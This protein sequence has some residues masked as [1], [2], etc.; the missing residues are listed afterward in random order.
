MCDNRIMRCWLVLLAIAAVRAECPLY[1]YSPDGVN[2][3]DCPVEIDIDATV[4]PG[5]CVPMLGYYNVGV[6][7]YYEFAHCT[8]CA[9]NQLVKTPCTAV[10]NTVCLTCPAFAIALNGACTCPANYYNNSVCIPCPAGSQSTIGSTACTQCPPDTYSD[11]G[12][13][14]V[15]CPEGSF[16]PN[17]TSR[18]PCPLGYYC[19]AK[20]KQPTPCVTGQICGPGS[21]FPRVCPAESFCPA[22]TF[23]QLCPVNSYCPQGATAPA[24]CVDK[25]ALPVNDSCPAGYAPA[26]LAYVIP[27]LGANNYFD[28]EYDKVRMLDLQTGLSEPLLMSQNLFGMLNKYSL[29]SGYSFGRPIVL[30]DEYCFF[31]FTHFYIA[32]EAKW[33][34]DVWFVNV[35]ARNFAYV[36]RLRTTAGADLYVEAATFTPDRT[37]MLMASSAGIYV[38]DLRFNTVSYLFGSEYVG[39][40]G[41][42]HI[43]VAPDTSRVVV[44]YSRDVL[45]FNAATKA[46]MFR[47]PS[48]INSITAVSMDYSANAAYVAAGP[49]IYMLDLTAGSWTQLVALESELV[50]NIIR[51]PKAEI[52]LT[53]V[54]SGTVY[55]FRTFDMRNRSFVSSSPLPRATVRVSHA[56]FRG[57]RQVAAQQLSTTPTTPQPT[58]TTPEPTTT[59]P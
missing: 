42:N 47:S 49:G 26:Y 9:A 52:L 7:G 12:Q 50:T 2:C 56:I 36:N 37:R 40:W 48:L 54:T 17:A 32:Q 27:Q 25:C 19:P 3:I 13:S 34:N 45:V 21:A 59:T 39:I 10:S 51:H 14:C 55:S 4:V 8:T 6:D 1:Q 28:A 11:A 15:A 57:C 33:Y 58:T 16:C 46:L 5:T 22:P 23:Q 43:S 20:A 18:F 24:P 44:A 31:T 41:L 29:H 53:F 35:T 30:W 38:L